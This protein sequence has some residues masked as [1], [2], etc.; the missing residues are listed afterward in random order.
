MKNNVT[1]TYKLKFLKYIF[2]V[3][4][5]V[6]I[7]IS[8]SLT[9]GT[10]YAEMDG[11]CLFSIQLQ[12]SP[13]R[14]RYIAKVASEVGNLLAYNTNT[15]SQIQSDASEDFSYRDLFVGKSSSSKNM[16]DSPDSF[17][18]DCLG[19]HDG[20]ST[21]DITVDYRN[22]PGNKVMHYDGTKEH[23]I[24]MDYA[25]Y[26]ARDSQSYKPINAYNSKMIFVGG[27]VGC[28]TCHSPLNPEKDHLVMSDFNSALCLSC[29]NR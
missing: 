13:M 2:S 5:G 23:P 26:S 18:K 25:A 14:E 20:T 15:D 4:S 24:G 16:E 10:A 17:S 27:R 9:E 11:T 21:K 7:L 6:C 12:S 29:H 19:C 8:A 22:T 3:V 1:T 28:L